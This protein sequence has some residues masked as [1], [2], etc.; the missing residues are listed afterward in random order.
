MYYPFIDE[1]T[2][3]AW[4]LEPELPE[5]IFF[6]HLITSEEKRIAKC[7]QEWKY[8][9]DHVPVLLDILMV[10]DGI[11]TKNFYEIEFSKFY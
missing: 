2:T 1:E 11:H 7:E 9:S 5:E 4:R 8:L 3:L 6:I 10:Q